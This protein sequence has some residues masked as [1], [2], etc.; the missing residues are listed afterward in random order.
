MANDLKV[1]VS[2]AGVYP[3]DEYD[4]YVSGHPSASPYHSSAWL[5]AIESAYQHMAW[6]VTVHNDSC[7]CG[8]LPLVEIN[9]PIGRRSLISLPFCDLGGV[10]ADDDNVKHLLLSEAQLLGAT[11]KVSELEVREGGEVLQEPAVDDLSGNRK[12]RMLCNL[13]SSSDALFKSYKPKL[14]S[15]IR[16]AEKNGLRAEVRTDIEAVHH[17]YEVF[18]RNMRRL[19]SPVHSREW[20]LELKRAYGDRMLVGLVFL[21]DRPVG[22]GI[23]LTAG[24]RASIPWASTLEQFNSL[25]PNMLLYWSLLSHVCDRGCSLFDFGRSTL[26]EGTYRF[27]K[28]WG[29][30]PYELNWARWPIGRKSGQDSEQSNL[31]HRISDL[32]P[33]VEGIW[34]CLPLAVANW[35]GPKLRR[36]ITL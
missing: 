1:R 29:A 14:R 31:P 10:L 13:P 6:L 32:R 5:S 33:L 18:A 15:Q 4:A 2:R 35:I 11:C 23:V 28:Q 25:A 30:R 34:R 7:L 22:G 19:G 3:M 16:K 27:K 12:V 17:F 8:V 26:G 20:F 36:Y 9:R 24:S 21:E